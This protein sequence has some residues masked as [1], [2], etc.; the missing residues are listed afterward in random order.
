MQ[1]LNIINMITYVHGS[2]SR[3]EIE[4]Q[5]VKISMFHTKFEVRVAEHNSIAK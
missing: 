1:C 4:S 5:D 2:W 3:F